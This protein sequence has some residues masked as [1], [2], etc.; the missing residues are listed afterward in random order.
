M[1]WTILIVTFTH[2]RTIAQRL[3]TEWELHYIR[4][5]IM[6]GILLEVHVRYQMSVP[7]VYII[8]MYLTLLQL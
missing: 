5:V 2:S 4:T 3:P 1:Y 7:P 6:K 8:F